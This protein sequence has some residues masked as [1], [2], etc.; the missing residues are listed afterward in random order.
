V[1]TLAKSDT[2]ECQAILDVILHRAAQR[3]QES[4]CVFFIETLK[5]QIPYGFS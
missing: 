5:M 1:Y 3:A 4:V 2:R